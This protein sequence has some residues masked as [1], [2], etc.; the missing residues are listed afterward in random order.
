MCGVV[1]CCPSPQRDT[2]SMSARM[3]QERYA[4]CRADTA[5]AGVGTAAM[6]ACTVPQ[7]Q[8]VRSRG[9]FSIDHQAFNR[10]EPV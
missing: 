4:W 10:I 6:G 2:S 1:C 7:R 3:S 8:G 9:P 5:E